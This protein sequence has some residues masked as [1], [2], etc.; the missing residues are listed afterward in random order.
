MVQS[1]QSCSQ[2]VVNDKARTDLPQLHPSAGFKQHSRRI[3][4]GDQGA[5]AFQL[6]FGSP[7]TNT[8]SFL[9][10]VGQEN[11]SSS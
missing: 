5:L 11:E 3:S 9:I 2:A 4:S 1:I 7:S 6:G 10:G 8:N